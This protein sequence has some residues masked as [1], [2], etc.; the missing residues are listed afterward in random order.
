[1]KKRTTQTI[2]FALG[3][4]VLSPT[5]KAQASETPN[6]EQE[7]EDPQEELKEKAKKWGL[8]ALEFFVET[9]EK[10][11]QKMEQ[12][13][14]Y[15]D[16]TIELN[17]YKHESLWLITDMPNTAPNEE[18][19]YYFVDKNSIPLKWTTYYDALGNKVKKS[20]PK[21]VRKYEQIRYFAIGDSENRFMIRNDYNLLNNT[22]TT[23]YVDF[24]TEYVW[25]EETELEFGRFINLDDIIP[26]DMQ[27]EKYSKQDLQ[28]ILEILNN[29]EYELT[30]DSFK[31]EQNLKK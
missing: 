19:H 30:S 8:K 17:I 23:N 26:E 15:V 12:A 31:R 24:D 14:D 28:E 25:E 18:R 2:L 3:L 9:G 10:A 7:T 6:I 11:D 13:E 22:W 4:S 29:C 21:A 16:E 1:M 5:I 20:D 27:K